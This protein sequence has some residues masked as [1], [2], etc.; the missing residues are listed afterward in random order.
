MAKTKDGHTAP[1]V[2][3]SS[4]FNAKANGEQSRQI[5]KVCL[6]ASATAVTNFTTLSNTSTNVPLEHKIAMVPVAMH[7]RHEAGRDAARSA[8]G[9]ASPA[10]CIAQTVTRPSGS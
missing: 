1:G 5:P 7:V 3:V 4:G 8:A 2:V 9:I 6:A 10:T